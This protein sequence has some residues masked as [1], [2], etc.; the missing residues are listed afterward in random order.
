MNIKDF[1]K[2]DAFRM[3][4]EA[5]DTLDR[6]RADGLEKLKV[7]QDVKNNSLEKERI[8]LINK[9]GEDHP[10]VKKI[11]S[12]LAY[13]IPFNESIDIEIDRSKI[14]M[15]AFDLDTWIV[16][17]RILDENIVG[18]KGLTVSLFN[19]SGNWNKQTKYASTDEKGYFAITYTEK[20]E[21]K[22]KALK[23]QKLFLTITDKDRRI[24][25]RESEPLYIM[26]GLI[27]YR[28]IIITKD[29]DAVTPPEPDE[30]V[31]P[32]SSWVVRGRVTDEKGQ[33]IGGLTIK[34]F[35]EDL[36][37]DDLL[38]EETTDNDGNYKI[39]YQSEDFRDLFEKRPDLYVKVIDKDNKT[40]YT[41]KKNIRCE[42]GRDEVID[43][44]IEKE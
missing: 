8:R 9:Y 28:E 30:K 15:P 7:L 26:P 19:E 11:D 5:L 22:V 12:E 31:I 4:D 10:R 18:I 2:D 23:S 6:Q 21:G 13:A 43:V 14:K 17:G 44:I 3:I 29:S 36:I 34:L 24:L 20:E 37:F 42:A 33:G 16:H 39:I 40:I 32:G 25:H 35:D 27:D 41:S 38:S 1:S